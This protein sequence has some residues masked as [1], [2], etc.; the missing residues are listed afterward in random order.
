MR[1][2][3]R[4]HKRRIV[5]VAKRDP[6][7][8]K[9]L[10]GMKGKQL[11]N[12]TMV[13]TLLFIF[14]LSLS[15]MIVSIMVERIATEASYQNLET[16]AIQ[17]A[18]NV[19]HQISSD[20][21]QLEL[22]ADIL[23]NHSQGDLLELQYIL[24]SVQYGEALSA[25]GILLPNQQMVMEDQ[26][27]SSEKFGFDFTAEAEQVPYVSD[28][29]TLPSNHQNVDKWI[30]QAVP[31]QRDGEI[32]G[33]LYGFVD[34]DRLPAIFEMIAFD[35]HAQMY[36]LDGKT[37]DALMDT[38][39]DGLGNLYLNSEREGK[40][41][42]NL[43]QTSK[44]MR[45]GGEGQLA[46]KSQTRGEYL[47]GHY[48]PIG[49]N[50]W[51]LLLTVPE[52]VV[53]AEVGNVRFVLGLL[54]A[55]E[56]IIFLGYIFWILQGIR[57]ENKQKEDQLAETLY[58]LDVQQTLFDA[59]KNSEYILMA[60][61]K[62]AAMVKAQ[63]AFLVSLE[64]TVVKET[65][66]WPKEDID[67]DDPDWKMRIGQ[68][69]VAVHDLLTRGES[70]IRY[71]QGGM[72][73]IETITDD[74]ADGLQLNNFMLVPVLDSEARLV[75]LLGCGNM[76]QKW[77]D[78]SL[79][80]CVVRNFMMALN[81]LNSYRKIQEMGGTDAL[82]GLKNRNSYQQS[83]QEYGTMK[84]LSFCCIYMDVNGLH[85][86]NN[87]LGHAAGDQMLIFIG[88]ALKEVFGTDDT[89][90]IGGD[91]FV[92]FCQNHSQQEVEAKVAAFNQTVEQEG[93]EVSVGIAWQDRSWHIETLIGKA[94]RKMYEV[95]QFYYHQKGDVTK[96]REMNHRL[97]EILQEKK[98]IDAFLGLISF[99]FMGV[100]VVNLST[101][102]TRIIYKPSYFSEMLEKSDYRFKPA[103]QQYIDT[104]VSIENR[105]ELSSVLD[106]SLLE[107]RLQDGKR[108]ECH[109]Q[110]LDGVK[111]IL[112][113]CCSKDYTPEQREIFWLFE[114]SDNEN[115]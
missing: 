50:Q 31:I 33:I 21:K 82:T 102:Q 60:L 78:A 66:A 74:A 27:Y 62:V 17:A 111:V 13:S 101:D 19:K 6:G 95:K 96:A 10:G 85:E 112:R 45:S 44:N 24:T 56:I 40:L 55:A 51:M 58:I 79:L 7:K 75:G 32:Q 115:K 35:G 9:E 86:L 5:S 8:R 109:Y 72:L 91:E 106:Y 107:Q 92:V 113:I 2:S 16:A 98:D 54:A 83:V 80:E 68:R 46:F 18:N 64:D 63:V 114:Q 77:K 42:T 3:V 39:H 41:G 59:H 69:L 65:Y 52:K 14:L 48:L 61:Q 43:Q 81:N 23:A 110:K 12:K 38:L 25:L 20:K 97:E 36:I 104:L 105:E 47:Y 49:V 37:G 11:L 30:Y 76:E 22:L 1:L 89:Y 57:K 94:E 90:R 103:F 100:Y 88:H 26:V 29:Y 108:V 67:D 34:L 93:Y 84:N 4:L 28:L 99:Y 71:P 53:F 73:D 70:V 87:H 15:F